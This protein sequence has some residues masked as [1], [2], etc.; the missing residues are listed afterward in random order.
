MAKVQLF[1]VQRNLDSAR[2]KCRARKYREKKYVNGRDRK[3]EREAKNQPLFYVFVTLTKPG[4]VVDSVVS[5][6]QIFLLSGRQ[7]FI[8][9]D[10][11]KD[12]SIYILIYIY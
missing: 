12:I 9:Y 10:F 4:V 1:S 6:G 8:F 5:K 2:N 3:R 11:R 7:L